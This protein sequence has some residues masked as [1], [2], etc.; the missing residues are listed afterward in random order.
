M[1]KWFIKNKDGILKTIIAGVILKF[2]LEVLPKTISDHKN[3][4]VN[5]FGKILGFSFSIKVYYIILFIIF[6][7]IVSWGYRKI[8]NMNKK[9]KIIEAKYFTDLYSLDITSNLNDAVED[10]RL[11]IVLSNN[12]AGD[13]H[14]GIIKKGKIIYKYKGNKNEKEYTEGGIIDLP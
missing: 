12:I 4:L 6:W 7:L 14:K 1:N 9:L 8:I 5:Y 3:A 2:V 11:K 13:P 10:N